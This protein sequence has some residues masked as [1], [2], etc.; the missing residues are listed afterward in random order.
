MEAEMRGLTLTL[1]RASDMTDRFAR[2][3]VVPVAAVF[4]LIIFG[5]V[6]TRFVFRMPIVS[7]EEFARIAFLWMCYLG[8]VICVKQECHI[9]FE[10]LDN[11]LGRT[12]PLF[13]FAIT[14]V[15]IAFYLFLVVKGVELFLHVLPTMFPASG[16]SQ[17]WMHGVL[18]ASCLLMTVHFAYFIFRDVSRL[19][20]ESA[21]QGEAK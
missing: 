19:M 11:L 20:G 3:A 21:D 12:R 13:N 9:R 8:A 14:L 5:G 17:A 15:S 6:L 1:Q 18:P 7:S 2:W 10:L 16:I 4:I